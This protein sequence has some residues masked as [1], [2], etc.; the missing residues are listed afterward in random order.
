M[1]YIIA[2]VPLLAYDF[3]SEKLCNITSTWWLMRD[4][5]LSSLR[6][7]AC[8]LLSVAYLYILSLCIV[9]SECG[10]MNISSWLNGLTTSFPPPA[11]PSAPPVMGEV[12]DIGAHWAVV[13]WGI[14]RKG[15]RNGIIISYVVQLEDMEGAVIWNVT[16]SVKDP[17]FK[18]PKSVTYNLTS[19]KPYT[20]YVWRVAATTTA[21]TGR[22]S[23]DG[24]MAHFRTLQWS[25]L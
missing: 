17:K 4:G 7:W 20:R 1:E 16:V 13:V 19:L 15:G 3:L 9:P 2:A 11:A 14:P 24:T 12:R 8:I 5:E 6:Y 10:M 22:F 23:S 18:S 25:E 21:G